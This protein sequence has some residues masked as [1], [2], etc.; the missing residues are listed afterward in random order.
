M[1]AAESLTGNRYTFS[2]S[3]SNNIKKMVVQDRIE[4]LF[5]G[6]TGIAA[7]SGIT[8]LDAA[9]FVQYTLQITLTVCT[10]YYLRKKNKSK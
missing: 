6:L 10:I 5:T 1:K 2:Q 8:L 3:K 7:I 4:T 9:A